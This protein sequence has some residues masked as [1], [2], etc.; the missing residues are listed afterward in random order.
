MRARARIRTHTSRWFYS[1][2][3]G[4]CNFFKW[5]PDQP[6]PS[7][8]AAGGSNSSPS[9]RSGGQGNF[10]ASGG[11]ILGGAGGGGEALQGGGVPW[12]GGSP[13]SMMGSPTCSMQHQQQYQ[14]QHVQ[15]S[16]Y[17]FGQQQQQQQQQLMGSPVPAA[18][19]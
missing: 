18:Q 13:F 3:S 14:A 12:A 17:A 2:Q 8:N 10:P 9:G 16:P 19:R 1:C 5:A 15:G 7:S 4:A 6:N 11:R